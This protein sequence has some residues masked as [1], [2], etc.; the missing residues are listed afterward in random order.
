MTVLFFLAFKI[1]LFFIVL[2]FFFL[3]LFDSFRPFH[4]LLS[5]ALTPG[6][7]TSSMLFHAR[8]SWGV[9]QILTPPLVCSPM[10][11]GSITVGRLS[12]LYQQCRPIV[13][14][15]L[16]FMEGMQSFKAYC[17]TCDYAYNPNCKLVLE[18]EFI[19]HLYPCSSTGSRLW[20]NQLIFMHFSVL[21]EKRLP[22]FCWRLI[23]VISFVSPIVSH[24]LP[25]LMKVSFSAFSFSFYSKYSLS[26]IYHSRH[27]LR[28]L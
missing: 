16:A 21:K 17:Y 18:S 24:F 19:S 1:S 22:T 23:F 25:V 9:T 20:G 15:R 4:R 27:D 2:F 28:H 26:S 10:L 12:A 14:W 13:L 11:S 3:L 7:R 5:T 8:T 6:Q